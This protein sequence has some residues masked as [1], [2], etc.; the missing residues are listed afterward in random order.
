MQTN[1]KH[2][3]IV[4]TVKRIITRTC[5]QNVTLLKPISYNV[6]PHVYSHA[7]ALQCCCTYTVG[8]CKHM[9]CNAATALLG[10]LR[11]SMMC[12]ARSLFLRVEM[13]S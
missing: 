11:I 10:L 6:H 5:D 9:E 4:L 8:L 12:G 13:C 3:F 7:C 2:L 1:T